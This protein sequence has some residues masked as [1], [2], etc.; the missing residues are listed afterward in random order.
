MID[1]AKAFD[2]YWNTEGCHKV[3]DNPKRTK[4]NIIKALEKCQEFTDID[5]YVMRLRTARESMRRLMVGF[6]DYLEKKKSIEISSVLPSKVFYDYPF[7][8]QLEMAKYLHEPHT[9]AEIRDRFDIDDRTMRKDLQALSDGIEVL[10]ARIRI[11][12]SEGKGRRLFYHTTLHPVFLP[13]NLTEVYALTVYLDRVL[14]KDDPNAEMI[15]SVSG[16]IKGQLS[17][18]ARNRLF[19]DASEYEMN[20]YIDDEELARSREG[21][22]AYLMKSGQTCSFWQNGEKKEG[23]FVYDPSSDK[24]RISLSDQSDSLIDYD[25][26]S[27]EFIA[28]K[29]KYD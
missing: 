16:R 12:K 23:R 21:I 14:G 11:E 25:P 20:R 13:L 27:I 28:G 26:G 9:R 1:L 24:Y 17:D 3:R 15:R 19:P 22:V 5:E 29:L 7:Q 2:E 4:N 10:G 8:R 18:Y 6:F